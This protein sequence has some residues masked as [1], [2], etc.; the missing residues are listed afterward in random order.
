[1]TLLAELVGTSRQ[2]AETASRN[3][4]TALL[5][6]CLRKLAPAEIEAAVAYLSGETRQ[7]RSGIGYALLRDAQPATAADVPSLEICDVDSVLARMA[8]I[9]GAGSKGERI[10]HLA[11][12]LARATEE[13]RDFLTRLLLGELRQGALE[14]LMIDAVA[15][16]ASLP[17]PAVRQAAMVAHGIVPVALA[18]LTEGASGLAK[19]SLALM[20]PIAPMLAQPAADVASALQALG[21]AAFEWKLD[22]ARVQVHKSGDDVRI[23]TRNRN[24]VTA[25]APEIVEAVRASSVAELMLDGEAIAL[26]ASG[27]PHPFQVTMRR[28]GRTLDV[29]E[30][31]ASLPLSVFFFDCMRFGA[32]VLTEAPTSQRIE[33]LQRALP[34]SLLMPRLVTSELA[35]GQAFYDD[36]LA[37]GHEGVMAKGLDAPYEAGRRAPSWLKVKKL[38]T[39]DLV[40]LA[41]EWGHGRRHGFL[42][43]LHLGARDE[44]SGGFVML[45]KTF[46]GMTDEMLAWQTT[47][48][49]ARETGRDKMTV[50]V[51]PE[52]VVEI[53]FND[54]QASPHYPG[55]LALRFARVKRYRDDKTAQD[56]DTIETVRAIYEGQLARG[57]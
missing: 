52:L 11:S 49:L 43:N 47:A 32:D 30:M 12:L 25:S 21:T 53:A 40:V 19:F 46:K 2:V 55:G 33:A 56:C 37:R 15:A 27:A 13:E 17:P 14:S 51:R 8:S 9:S 20:Q 34:A 39:L 29:T 41:A 24:D 35:E 44:V 5:A 54:L 28:F 38:H 1:M 18:V 4:K 48:L 10:S 50:Y 26:Q 7:G 23:F 42:S 57:S 22:G 36:A 45:G 6:D 3:A 31:R 16:A